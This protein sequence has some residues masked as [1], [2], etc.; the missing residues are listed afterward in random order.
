MV[1]VNKVILG[2]MMSVFALGAM[3]ISVHAD[4]VLEKVDYTMDTAQRFNT[5]GTFVNEAQA[6]LNKA[7]KDMLA[8]E[9]RVQDAKQVVLKAERELNAAKENKLNATPEKV[10][11][12]VKKIE[13][14]KE[15][16]RDLKDKLKDAKQKLVEK[17]NQLDS[18]KDV[19]IKASQKVMD[20][21][22]KVQSATDAVVE[23]KKEIDALKQGRNVRTLD[24][25]NVVSRANDP[26][27]ELEL[28]LFRLELIA[29]NS[30]ALLST[31]KEEHQ[32]AVAETLAATQEV[33]QVQVEVSNTETELSEN[34]V[35][36]TQ[37]EDFLD[38]LQNAD[39]QLAIAES[40]VKESR[41]LLADAENSFAAAKLAQGVA[42]AKLARAK[43]E[44]RAQKQRDAQNDTME[45]AIPELTDDVKQETSDVL[46]AESVSD[47]T[48]SDVILNSE[49]P[50]MSSKNSTPQAII[51]ALMAGLL[52]VGFGYKKRD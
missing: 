23:K 33:S 29:A 45:L 19:E 16:M 48:Q 21:T 20:Q 36:I 27:S 22:Y 40:R 49:L 9:K 10:S 47:N 41:M 51:A 31:Y 28:E 52:L 18:A 2:T 30:G 37:L 12:T 26:L 6:N 8:A 14:A 1:N 24:A 17:Q 7:N 43:A 32:N 34:E 4:E 5:V 11:D 13:T 38:V 44:Q 3:G 15:A 35:K 42:N 39:I 50:N 25:E 46:W